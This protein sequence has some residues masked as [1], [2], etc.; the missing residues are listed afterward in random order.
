[1]ASRARVVIAVGSALTVISL[2]GGAVL[3]R[4]MYGQPSINPTA[5][6]AALLVAALLFGLLAAVGSYIGLRI[7]G[8]RELPYRLGGYLA[9]AYIVVVVLI[10]LIPMTVTINSNDLQ[11]M[12]S[13]LMIPI[14]CGIALPGLLAYLLARFSLPRGRGE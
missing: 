7:A 12:V 11:G 2:I 14:I 1:M 5:L 13:V 10:G 8:I 3:L 6:T 9:L 4:Q